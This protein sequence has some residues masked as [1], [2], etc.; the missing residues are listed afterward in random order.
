[1]SEVIGAPAGAQDVRD[2]FGVEG[3]AAGCHPAQ[4]VDELADIADAILEQVSDAGGPAARCRSKELGG[5][6]GFDV[7]GEDQHSGAGVVAADGDCRPDTLVGV[8]AR[9]SHVHD[10]NIRLVLVHGRSERLG[11]AHGGH[12]LVSP[13]GQDLDQPRPDNGGVFGDDDPHSTLLLSGQT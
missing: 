2:D 1:V 9:H 5:V 12:R 3:G 13:V 11:I 6:A 10:G 8:V 7:L 4:R